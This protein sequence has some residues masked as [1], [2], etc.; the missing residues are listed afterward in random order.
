MPQAENSLVIPVQEINHVEY[1]AERVMCH[2]VLRLKSDGSQSKESMNDNMERCTMLRK[3]NC[4][5]GTLVMETGPADNVPTADCSEVE[6]AHNTDEICTK[7]TLCCINWTLRSQKKINSEKETGV[8]PNKSFIDILQKQVI[9]PQRNNVAIDEEP[10]FR[11]VRAVNNYDGT[12]CNELT[13]GSDQQKFTNSDSS[14][15]SINSGLAGKKYCCHSKLYK[16]MH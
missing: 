8:N 3:T 14:F 5:A 2:Y 6:L 12:S 11:D 10:M 16:N 1:K 13:F 4:C 9:T 7:V 15:I